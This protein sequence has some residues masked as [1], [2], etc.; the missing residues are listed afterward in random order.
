[1]KTLQ[2]FGSTAYVKRLGLLKKLEE[3]NKKLYFV[4]YAPNGYRLWNP[5]KKKIIIAR[6]VKFLETNISENK[7]LKPE[8]I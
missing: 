4:G 7:N 1:M 3:R 5:Q 2:I 6:D 8:K